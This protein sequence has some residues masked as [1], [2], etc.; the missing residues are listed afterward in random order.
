VGVKVLVV[1]KQIVLYLWR[2]FRRAFGDRC[3]TSCCGINMYVAPRGAGTGYTRAK[4]NTLE[5]PGSIANNTYWRAH[6]VD[7]QAPAAYKVI[8]ELQSV[9][10]S[11]MCMMDPLVVGACKDAL[12][13]D[14]KRKVCSTAIVTAGSTTDGFGFCNSIHLDNHDCL[15]RLRVDAITKL[16]R[17]AELSLPRFERKKQYILDWVKRFGRLSVP[18][19][20][21]YEFLGEF[22]DHSTF[23]FAF[24]LF[25][26][27]HMALLLESGT[28]LQFY[29]GVIQHLTSAVVA[30][31]PTHVHYISEDGSVLAWGE[32]RGAGGGG[33]TAAPRGGEGNGGGGNGGGGNGGG[34]NGGGGNGGGGNAGGGG[35]GAGGDVAGGIALAGALAGVFVQDDNATDTDESLRLPEGWIVESEEELSQNSDWE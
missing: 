34:G 1:P 27:I 26:S 33:G 17:S 21:A 25:P 6:F 2:T 20:C 23:L 29:A 13:I 15:S 19:T 22:N 12:G 31:G 28:A 3:V 5:G 32:G 35:G 30:V 9:A 8:N 24:F 11:N 18:T 16:L 7:V 4:A 10:K 14:D